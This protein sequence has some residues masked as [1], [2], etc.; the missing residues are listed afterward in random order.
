MFMNFD[1]YSSINT[2]PILIFI[3]EVVEKIEK[4]MEEYWSEENVSNIIKNFK[5]DQQQYFKMHKMDKIK[6]Q[7]R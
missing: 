4:A 2:I 5:N 3:G 6:Y 7:A 1:N